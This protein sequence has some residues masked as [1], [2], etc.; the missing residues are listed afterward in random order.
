[1]LSSMATFGAAAALAPRAFAEETDSLWDMLAR[2]RTMRTDTNES[3]AAALSAID[4]N[5]P[6]LSFDTANNLQYAIA[7]YEQIRAS[8]GWE[9]VSQ[10]VYNLALGKDSRAVVELKRRLMW[11]GD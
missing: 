5:E 3:T 8:G 4:T 2:N 7:H 1:L 9:P 11:T 10:E 6:I